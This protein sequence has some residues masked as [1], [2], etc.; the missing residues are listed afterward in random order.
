MPSR[1]RILTVV[2][3][4]ACAGLVWALRQSPEPPVQQREF[5][6][7]PLR[8]DGIYRSMRGPTSSRTV[9][10]DP[11]EKPRR[12]WIRGVDVE[13]IDAT[14]AVLADGQQF[15][16]HVNLS[17]PDRDSWLRDLEPMERQGR[18]LPFNQFTLVQGH[19]SIDF[20]AGFALPAMSDQGFRILSMAQNQDPQQPPFDLRIRSRVRFHYDDDLAAPPIPLNKL[21]WDIR[22][23]APYVPE[24]HDPL[25][26]G[27]SC[28]GD[29]P[30]PDGNG[31]PPVLH[32]AV[33]PGR[34]EYRAQV[35]GV[36]KIPFPTTAHHISAHLHVYGVSLELRDL[37]ADTSLFKSVATTNPT[38]TGIVEMTHYSSPTGV[39]LN[40]NHRYELIAVY[41][42]PTPHVVD[43]MAVVYVYYK[44][45]PPTEGGGHSL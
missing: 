35:D 31:S 7:Q 5:E 15:I 44:D 28:A 8:L 11:Q 37:T 1:S 34:H 18:W 9:R 30:I 2:A 32:F 45:V 39:P 24:V 20:P 38:A 36:S 17:Y 27:E 21:S 3:L 29:D 4:L 6:S 26:A 41:D 19:Y 43:A 23:A 33:P 25:R 22:V 13:P 40:P 12:I 42:N 10:L 16:C 14:G